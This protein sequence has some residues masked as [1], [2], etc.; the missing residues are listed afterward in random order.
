MTAEGR[1]QYMAPW[2]ERADTNDGDIVTV[3]CSKGYNSQIIPIFVSDI[4]MKL[5]PAK[6]SAELAME[7]CRLSCEVC[8]RK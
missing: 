8:E 1:C 6:S 2:T 7:V 3:S 5:N 4:R